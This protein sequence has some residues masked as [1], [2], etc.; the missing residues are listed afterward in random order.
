[1][2][3]K[4]FPKKES[5]RE[6]VGKMFPKISFVLSVELRSIIGLSI[7]RTEGNLKRP[8][9]PGF[10]GLVFLCLFDDSVIVNFIATITLF[11]HRL[12]EERA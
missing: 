1:M 3:Q 2:R 11:L 10:V 5:L 7:I 6:L 8:G 9:C 12:D 4:D